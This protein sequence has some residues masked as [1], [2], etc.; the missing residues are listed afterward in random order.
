MLDVRKDNDTCSRFNVE[1]I[2]R[3]ELSYARA[4]SRAD[5]QRADVRDLFGRM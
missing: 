1:G 4:N 2:L 3:R 5:P